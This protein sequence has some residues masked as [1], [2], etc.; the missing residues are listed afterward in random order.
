MKDI[1]DRIKELIEHLQLSN[2]SFAESIDIAPAIISHVL[3]GRNNP[4]LHLIQQITN[5]Y[6]NVNLTYLLNGEGSLLMEESDKQEFSSESSKSNVEQQS[7]ALPP[8]A[9]YVSPPSGAP[10][11][12]KQEKAPEETQMPKEMPKQQNTPPVGLKPEVA[13]NERRDKQNSEKFTNV[14]KASGKRIERIVVFYTD[15]S[16]REYLPEA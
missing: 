1:A 11:L 4:S 6:T 7:A 2:K 3:S 15:R 8:G 9:R 16:F 13:D 10:V 12:P 14:Y 5:V